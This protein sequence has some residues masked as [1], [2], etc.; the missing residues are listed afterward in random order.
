[1]LATSEAASTSLAHC[2]ADISR[3]QSTYATAALKPLSGRC[4]CSLKTVKGAMMII[5][6]IGT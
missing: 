2:Q 4:R 1:M 5:D 3:S 6:L